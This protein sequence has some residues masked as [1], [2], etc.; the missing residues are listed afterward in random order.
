MSPLAAAQF[1]DLLLVR[2]KAMD[3]N[4]LWPDLDNDRAGTSNASST[5]KIGHR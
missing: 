3:F 1:V 5:D 2:T 4:L